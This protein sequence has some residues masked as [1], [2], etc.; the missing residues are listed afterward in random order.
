MVSDSRITSKVPVTAAR[1]A[2]SSALPAWNSNPGWR[3]RARSTIAGL[4][5]MPTPR[6]GCRKASV[7]PVPQPTS[8]TEAP[9]GTRKRR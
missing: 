9:S 6:D 3:C 4:R 5:S 2:G 1:T 8:R 7:S